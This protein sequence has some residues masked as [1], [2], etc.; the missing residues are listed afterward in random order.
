MF[1]ASGANG[2]SLIARVAE[3]L[4]LIPILLSAWSVALYGEWIII[5]AIPIYLSLSDMGFVLAGSNELAR[6]G[7]G[8]DENQIRNF[9]TDYVSFFLRWSFLILG[10]IVLVAV[11]LPLASLL[12]LEILSQTE[13][14]TIFALL[15]GSTLASQNGLTMLAGLRVRRLFHVGLLIGAL[16]ALLRLL[17][18]YLS[19]VAFGAGP[20]TVATIILAVTICSYFA[21]ALTL[22][23]ANFPV[24]WRPFHKTKEPMLPYLGMGLEF[25]LMPLAQAIVLQGMVIMVGTA[26]G[27]AAAAIFSTH[28]TLSRFT[29]QVLQLAVQPL[30]AE[31]GLLQKDEHRQQL[32]SILLSTSRLTFW[33]SLATALFLMFAGHVIFELWT[34]G[35][36]DFIPTLF[37]ALIVST[38]LEGIWR[39]GASIRLGSNRHRPVVWAYLGLSAIGLFLAWILAQIGDVSTI[40]WTLIAI[41]ALMCIWII[42]VT[43]PLIDV[44]SPVYLRSMLTPPTRE[45]AA[46]KARLIQRLAK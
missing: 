28:R 43:A 4:L 31:A 11:N 26:L 16:A 5:S 3:Q 7:G 34:G 35:K 33:L 29:S 39:I 10:L 40:A 8:A 37:F 27:P 6:R 41:D 20:V 36:I 17:L 19:V 22:R 21:Q 18:T 45:V 2:L 13:A 14:A 46:L 1:K 38:I 15:A 12:G 23:I 42:R 44:A 24:T 30:N 25:M 32:R 9:F